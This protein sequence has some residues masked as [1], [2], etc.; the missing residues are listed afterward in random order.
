MKVNKTDCSKEL[1][2]YTLSYAQLRIIGYSRAAQQSGSASPIYDITIQQAQSNYDFLLEQANCTAT[3]D[4]LDCLRQA[5]YES[6]QNAV[7]QT[8]SIFS[9]QAANISWGP[10]VDGVFLKQSIR[11]SL[12]QGKYAQV[13]FVRSECS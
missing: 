4:T 11:Q 9:Y 6:I 7:A 5:P 3:N 2:W 12:S 8:P 1:S 13:S 10:L